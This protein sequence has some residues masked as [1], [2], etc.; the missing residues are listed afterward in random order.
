[1]RATPWLRRLLLLLPIITQVN[2]ETWAKTIQVYDVNDLLEASTATHS[3][4]FELIL[5]NDIAVTGENDEGHWTVDNSLF[6]NSNYTIKSA[7]GGDYAAAEGENYS[8]SFTGGGKV[9]LQE[10]FDSCDNVLFEDL[11]HVTFGDCSDISALR[12]LNDDLVSGYDSEGG[13][14]LHIKNASFKNITGRLKISDMYF[15]SGTMGGNE[16][17]AATATVYGIGLL[18]SKAE[19][20]NVAGGIE[21]SNIGIKDKVT[22]LIDWPRWIEMEGVALNAAG[23]T[24]SENGTSIVFSGNYIDQNWSD[25]MEGLGYGAAAYLSGTNN[26]STNAGELRFSGNEL[27]IATVGCGAALFLTDGSETT[28]T[29]QHR[30]DNAGVEAIISFTDNRIKG[31]HN[32][33]SSLNKNMYAYGGA[34]C[35]G[36]SGDAGAS[37]HIT[38]NECNVIFKGNY[39][40]FNLQETASIDDNQLDVYGGAVYVDPGSTLSITKNRQVEFSNNYIKMLYQDTNDDTHRIAYGGALYLGKGA[41]AEFS[42]N[43]EGVIFS[44]NSLTIEGNRVKGDGGAIYVDEQATLTLKSNGPAIVKWEIPGY[45]ITSGVDFGA[46]FHDNHINAGRGGAIFLKSG[47]QFIIDSPESIGFMNNTASTAGGAIYAEAG[48]IIKAQLA[49][50]CGLVFEG[51]EAT[52]GAAMYLESGA[53]LQVPGLEVS[54]NFATD[55]GGGI[56]MASSQKWSGDVIGM[57]FFR[58]EA[59]NSG[60]PGGGG[61][62]AD[63]GADIKIT[64]DYVNLSFEENLGS[65]IVATGNLEI[66]GSKRGTIDFLTNESPYGGAI[67]GSNADS[68]L[69]SNNGASIRFQ[70]NTATSGGA[71]DWLAAHDDDPDN[72]VVFRENREKISFLTNRAI[73]SNNP[74]SAKGGA[75]YSENLSILQNT[76]D[77]LFDGNSSTGK[78]GAIYANGQVNVSDNDGAI[79]FYDNRSGN[80]GA[81]IY[82]TQVTFKW[83]EADVIFEKNVSSESGGAIY[84]TQ[85]DFHYN[86]AETIFEGNISTE[87]G[88]AIYATQADFTYNGTDII[89]EGNIST[90]SGGA[91]YTTQG[92]TFEHN[93]YISFN[94]NSAVYGGALNSTAY[95]G[96]NVGQIAFTGNVATKAEDSDIEH[97]CAGGAIYAASNED[98]SYSEF[99]NNAGSILFSGNRAEQKG[100]LG[101]AIYVDSIQGFYFQQNQMGITFSGNESEGSGGAIAINQTIFSMDNNNGP[102]LFEN[103]V[104]KEHGGA[105]AAYGNDS[106]VSFIN[107]GEIIF[108]G[109]HAAAGASIFSEGLVEIRNNDNVLFVGAGG[110]ETDIHLRLRKDADDKQTMMNISAPEGKNITFDHTRIFIEI[111]ANKPTATSSIKLNETYS[112]I[113]Q[114][115]SIVFTNGSN[116]MFSGA[117]VSLADGCLEVH[118]STLG[119]AT[120]SFGRDSQGYVEDSKLSVGTVQLSSNSKLTFAGHN[121][122]TGKLELVTSNNELNFRLDESHSLESLSTAVSAAALSAGNLAWRNADYQNRVTLDTNYLIYLESGSYVLMALEEGIL[123]KGGQY[124]VLTLPENVAWIHDNEKDFLVYQHTKMPQ[125]LVWTNSSGTDIWNHADT[126]WVAEGMQQPLHFADGF[127]VYF[128][129]ACTDPADVVL[130]TDVVPENVVVDAT[131]DYTFTGEGEI[132]GNSSLVKKGSGTLTL[133]QNNSFSG[134]IALE[135]GSLQAAADN[136][137]GTGKVTTQQETTLCITG[138][139]E[140]ILAAEG[141]DIR[142]KVQIDAGAALTFEGSAGSQ[143]SMAELRGEGKLAVHAD[144]AKYEVWESRDF[145][146]DITVIGTNTTVIL[147]HTTTKNTDSNYF[148]SGAGVVLQLLDESPD[149]PSQYGQSFTITLQNGGSLQV[150]DGASFATDNLHLEAGAALIAGECEVSL[151]DVAVCSNTTS[152]LPEQLTLDVTSLGLFAGTVYEQ[153]G[154]VFSLDGATLNLYGEGTI[155][156]ITDLTP[157]LSGGLLDFLLFEDV[158]SVKDYTQGAVQF[159]VAGYEDYETTLITTDNGAVYVRLIPEP[160][161]ATL[162]MAA[163]CLLLLRRRRV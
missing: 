2:T 30:D 153:Y 33:G 47:A 8:I 7:E 91:I 115:G 53:T 114:S 152:T 15:S 92:A 43:T 51:N 37:L 98:F 1:M 65:A 109:N 146:G 149:L 147:L 16:L 113:E 112:G 59:M 52:R 108:R 131:R 142:G 34:I 36:L 143:E 14:F 104:A 83:N 71:I 18:S 137:L 97:F 28:I 63:N 13:A 123:A 110:S 127:R 119:A 69:F 22:T 161:T 5:H 93:K 60:Q 158:Y 102:L 76:G 107:N 96:E 29:G 135:Q 124:D 154:A 4:P 50:D 44:G 111:P 25:G 35:L 31:Q 129:D 6:F 45:T 141:T 56:Y 144:N 130:S 105:I 75:I 20:H 26:F 157:I 9:Q 55:K 64:G 95:F 23:V 17:S 66:T 73:S 94:N 86:G 121:T 160:T 134:G 132:G 125:E 57:R 54:Y 118:N 116:A 78:G 101:G 46:F 148:A 89:F 99:N 81:A 3:G 27:K 41:T 156:L 162:S 21:F 32:D 128:T 159:V 126:N 88:G 79:T 87:S 100:A 85:A 82:A 136:A 120:L 58:N 12:D 67:Y 72:D 163:L 106:R 139:A 10:V 150:A 151:Q 38:D 11:H 122:L 103:N 77:I 145:K 61:I 80:N 24:F 140:V 48:S 62:Y 49:H 138:D 40:D 155:T 39:I 42:E 90:E 133:A 74:E 68:L 117:A 70:D 19:F 84:A